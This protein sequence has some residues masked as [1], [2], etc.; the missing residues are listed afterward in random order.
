M[1][2]L[3]LEIE[4]IEKQNKLFEKDVEIISKAYMDDEYIF[5]NNYLIDYFT[6]EE[7]KY[8]NI[9]HLVKKKIYSTNPTIIID[10]P[11]LMCYIDYYFQFV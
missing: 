7:L 6:K 5:D 11:L 2:S 8:E 9:L 4:L 10:E 1:N 3:K